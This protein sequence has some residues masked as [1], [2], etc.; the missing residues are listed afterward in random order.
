[1][2]TITVNSLSTSNYNALLYQM[3]LNFEGEKSLVYADSD[4][5]A[6]IGIGEE[7][8]VFGLFQNP[9]APTWAETVQ[10]YQMLA[11]HR[12]AITVYDNTFWNPSI[13]QSLNNTTYA[14]IG[15]PI[16]SLSSSL[17][18][19]SGSGISAATQ[20]VETLQSQYAILAHA[21]LSAFEGTD[22]TNI[23]L[24]PGR[25]SSSD[26]VSSAYAATLDASYSAAATGPNLLIASTGGPGGLTPDTGADTLI[27]GQANDTLYAGSG[28]DTFDYAS[29]SD[30][31]IETIVLPD[32]SGSGSALGAVENDQRTRRSIS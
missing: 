18:Y 19:S 28:A 24:N 3:L 27:G 13:I 12:D 1:M 10:A 20:L 31:G 26:P 21:D 11:L 16:E 25:A 23:F 17:T 9:A 30:T 29:S 2:A 6:T 22:A 7:S 8:Q 14:S 15:T 5:N 32:P 4:G